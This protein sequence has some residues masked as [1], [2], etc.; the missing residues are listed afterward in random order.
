MTFEEFTKLVNAHDLT[1]SY[2]DDSSCY[3]RGSAELNVIRR[4]ATNFPLRE[5]ERVWNA[6]VDRKLVANASTVYKRRV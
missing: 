3:R 5:V 4:E 2:S 1:F 6:A